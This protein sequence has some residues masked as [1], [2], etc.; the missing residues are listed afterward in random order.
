MAVWQ[1]GYRL[2]FAK[3]GPGISRQSAVMRFYE[4][5]NTMSAG[6]QTLHFLP[7]DLHT[8]IEKPTKIQTDA[9]ASDFCI[10]AVYSALSKYFA[11]VRSFSLRAFI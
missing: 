1:R 2:S 8:R 9:S 4:A 5:D 7:P 6:N 3:K 11:F 10:I